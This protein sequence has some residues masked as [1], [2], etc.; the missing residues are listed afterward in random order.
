MQLYADIAFPTPTRSVFTYSIPDSL[1]GSLTVGMRAWVPLRTYMA[2]GMVVKIHTEKPDFETLAIQKVLD[3]SRIFS[4]EL[5]ELSAWAHQFYYCSLGEVIQAALPSGL[6]FVSNKYVRVGENTDSAYLE[7]DIEQDIVEALSE[8]RISLKESKKRWQTASYKK[9]FNKLLKEEKI[10]IWEELQEK[11]PAKLEKQWFWKEGFNKQNL[12]EVL[13]GYGENLN[14]WQ[15]GLKA[16]IEEAELPLSGPALKKKYGV[17]TSSI[18]RIA[19]EGLIESRMVEADSLKSEHIYAPENIKQLNEQQQSAYSHIKASIDRDIYANFVLYGITGSGKT[20]V[21]IH[22]IKHVLEQDKGALVLLPEIA[23]TPQ[24]VA[25]FYEIFGDNIAVLH[26]RLNDRERAE[27]WKRLASGDCRI[28]IGA[29]SAIFAPVEDIG[30]I[31]IDEEHDNSYKQEDPAPRYHTREVAIMRAVQ[32]KAVVV[33]GSATPSMHALHLVSTKKSTL[34]ELSE[35]HADAKLP[36]VKL[37]NLTQYRSAMRGPLS[38]PLYEAVKFALDKQE[39]VILLQNRRGF[40]SYLQCNTCGHIPQSPQCSVSLTYHKHK[41]MLLCH[42]SGYSRKADTIC[43]KC[44][45]RDISAKGLGSEQVEQQIRELFPDARTLRMD[46]DT[47]SGKSA[48]AKIIGSFAKG[49]A[50]ILIGT[51]LV[52]KGL[53]FPNVTLV[54]VI[55]A[56][57]ELAF[58]SFQAGERTYQLLSQVAGRAGRSNKAGRVFIQS[59]QP[60]MLAEVQDHNFK[61]FARKELSYRKAL[62]YPPYSRLVG[63]SFKGK[64]NEKVATAARMFSECTSRVLEETQILGPSPSTINRLYQNYY[65]ELTLKLDT[66]KG[67]HAIE[68][69]LDT[70]MEMYLKAKPP[71]SV[72]VNVNVGKI[73]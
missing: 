52:A 7:N 53:D 4:N 18:N 35:R 13:N 58:P 30:I 61:A 11:V 1:S 44:Q 47:T 37:I 15:Q 22:A 10:S 33:L 68:H 56:D 38:V 59:S 71:S 65:W 14:L 27:A 6:N 51:Q 32:N 66:E 9:A 34:L 69:L 64:V 19:K 67:A 36:E 3:K 41:N 46:R 29:R 26:S 63:I 28:A 16:L 31:I 43:E 23:L 25:R 20:E 48:H 39:Q 72:R 70:I 17:S 21:Y 73:W 62:Y 54:G 2:I 60:E 45:S 42:Y 8:N 12:N 49:E 57:T 55:D 40:S 24:T 50:D 5:L